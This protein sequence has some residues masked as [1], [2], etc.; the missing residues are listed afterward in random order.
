[1]TQYID[2]KNQHIVLSSAKKKNNRRFFEKKESVSSDSGQEKKRL[3][4]KNKPKAIKNFFEKRIIVKNFKK[5]LFYKEFPPDCI[6]IAGLI[7]VV[8]VWAVSLTISRIIHISCC[9]C[10]STGGNL[11][12]STP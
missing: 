9:V 8:V 1:M 5:F 6:R 7:F 12:T 4:F 11:S 10:A 2:L 3:V